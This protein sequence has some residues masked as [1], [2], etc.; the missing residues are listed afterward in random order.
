MTQPDLFDS[1]T[2]SG[3]SIVPPTASELARNRA[4]RGIERAI[5]HAVRIDPEWRRRALQAVALFARH[6]AFFLTEDLRAQVEDEGALPLPPDG[7]AFGAVMQ[8][9]AR[10]G[11]I[12]ADGYAP[13]NSSNRSPKVRWRSLIFRV[14]V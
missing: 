10:A 3:S 14:A 8:D 13:A 12:I 1:F 11:Y 2:R 4:E 6:H 7:R 5:T 9:A